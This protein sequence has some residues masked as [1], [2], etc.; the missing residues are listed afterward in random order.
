[1][2]C[3]TTFPLLLGATLVGLLLCGCAT[4]AVPGEVDAPIAQTAALPSPE[5]TAAEAN[6]APPADTPA[7]EMS[8]TPAVDSALQTIA[9][10][11]R[12]AAFEGDLEQA[13]A[14]WRQVVDQSVSEAKV[15]AVLQLGRVYLEAGRYDMAIAQASWAAAV[16]APDELAAQALGLLGT[17]QLAAGDW[18]GA[19]QSLSAYLE[20]DSSAAPYVLWRIAKAHK[21]IGDLPAQIAALES[22]DAAR[23]EPSF[24]AEVLAELASA[25]RANSD[26]NSAIAVYD[27]ILTFAALPDYRAL[28][29]HYKG[30]TLREASHEQDAI[31][32][33]FQVANSQP[34]SFAAYLALQEL[35]A[36]PEATISAVAVEGTGAVS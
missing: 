36:L 35:A 26:P 33:F 9:A 5:A 29:S 22:I 25:Y 2:N 31:V 23:L 10:Q 13:I 19:A 11:A 1:M 7:P 6:T 24:R 3:R 8:A 4:P 20:V 32:S 21:A 15:A 34:E 12:Q 17:A 14:L 30:E 28:I 16:E 27:E 18:R